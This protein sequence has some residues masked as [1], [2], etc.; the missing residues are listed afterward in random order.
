MRPVIEPSV[1]LSDGQECI[2]G[3]CVP[4]PGSQLSRLQRDLWPRDPDLLAHMR[5]LKPPVLQTV[6]VRFR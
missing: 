1:P 2:V 5:L 4:E 3:S 6:L